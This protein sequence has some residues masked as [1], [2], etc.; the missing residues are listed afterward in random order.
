MAEAARQVATLAMLVSEHAVV[1]HCAVVALQQ[2]EQERRQQQQ[3]QPFLRICMVGK[4]KM[5]ARKS[6]QIC[7]TITTNALLL[8]GMACDCLRKCCENNEN[9][10][11]LRILGA[12]C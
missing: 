11:S 6:L 7:L 12:C 5:N 9:M 10:P 3:L 8:I 1:T 4:V 2:E